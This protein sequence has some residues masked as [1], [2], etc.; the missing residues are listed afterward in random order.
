MKKAIK[1]TLAVTAGAAAVAGAA[2]AVPYAVTAWG[3]STYLETGQAPSE[4]VHRNLYKLADINNGALGNKITFNSITD[5]AE[6]GNEIDFTSVQK[7]APDGLA[8]DPHGM[9]EGGDI[10]VEDGQEYIVRLYVHNNS[11]KGTAGVS[12]GTKVAISG[13]NEHGTW[14]SKTNKDGKQ[15]VE[16][17]GFI[18]SDNATP[19]EYWDYVRFNSNTSFHL[20][21]VYG[22]A[23]IYNRG[24]TGTTDKPISAADMM[25]ATDE[26]LKAQT[27]TGRPLSD[28]I[29]LKTRADGELDGQLIGFDAL[30]GNVPGCYEYSSYITIRVKAVFDAPYT[31]EKKVRKLGDKEWSEVVDA[32]IGDQVEFQIE[33]NNTS[34]ETQNDVMIRDVLPGNLK[35][36]PGTTK[37]YNANH[38]NWASVTP[39]GDIVTRG[40]NIGSYVGSADGQN[41]GNAFVRFTAEVVDNGLDCGENFIYN[42]GRASYGGTVNEDS[43][44]V[45]TNKVCAPNE[46]TPDVP[47]TDTP[48][49]LP[50]TGPMAVTGGVIA[51]GAVV[52]AAGYFLASR[53][54]LR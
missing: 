14:Q 38:L 22:S 11:P 51:T 39:D 34:T 24:A 10:T 40:I 19:H 29:V 3:D 5:V 25:T 30:D 8:I 9:W 31:V 27:I 17:N 1:N 46:T 28:D 21:Y 20:D 52:T 12:T 18:T 36:V 53:K 47:T 42:W 54:Q 44:M 48:S 45:R 33:Y 32:E 15:E 26:Q 50:N 6:T 49:S 7:A 13:V 35:Y 43:A 4:T 37:L 23:M 16:L 41:G 2:I